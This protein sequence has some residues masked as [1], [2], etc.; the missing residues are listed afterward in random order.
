V[1]A[2]LDQDGEAVVNA[3]EPASSDLALKQYL[4][5]TLQQRSDL[6]ARVQAMIDSPPAYRTGRSGHP[7]CAWPEDA[8]YV[9]GRF[10]GFVMPRI[11]TGS[12]VTV[13]DVATSR[14]RTW[15]DRVAV[16]E[17]FARAVALL[18]DADVVMAIC[19]SGTC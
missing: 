12:A 15:R 13:H 17:N 10:I 2:Q 19:R 11:D 14:D 3:V 6:E 8:A 5:D 1:G 9:S 4:P 18:H 16:A 7:S